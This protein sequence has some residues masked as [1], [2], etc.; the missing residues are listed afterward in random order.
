MENKEKH[1]HAGRDDSDLYELANR[2]SP[3]ELWD[4]YIELE[5]RASIVR[6]LAC[7]GFALAHVI[8]QTAQT[9]VESGGM[10]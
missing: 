5:R 3:Q 9:L 10:N 6:C 1:N 7:G 8:T 2:L 4:I